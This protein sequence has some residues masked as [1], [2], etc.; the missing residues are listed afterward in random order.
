MRPS[1]FQKKSVGTSQLKN[2]A[3]TLKK[4]KKNSVT[5]AK[6]KNRSLLAKDFREGQLPQGATGPAGGALSG[7]YPNPGIA[8]GAIGPNQ[9][10]PAPAAR[11]LAG[12]SQVTDD[13]TNIVF[14]LSETTLNQGNLFSN[15]EDVLIITSPGVYVVTGMVAWQGNATGQR[16]ARLLLNGNTRVSEV[17]TPGNLGTLR[18]TVSMVDRFVAG[19]K[20]QIGGY[21]ASG[22][23][24][25]TILGAGQ[26]AVQLT[27]AWVGP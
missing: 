10:L 2:R 4:L 24:L 1:I 16:Q 7:N 19:D 11:A 21:Q 15:E 6:V 3:V 9:L 27:G 14:T 12:S 5:T 20:I 8:P 18:Q 26:G 13:L 17:S 22:G 23:S 25:Q